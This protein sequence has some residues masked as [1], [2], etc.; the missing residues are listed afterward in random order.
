MTATSSAAPTKAAPQDRLTLVGGIT[1]GMMSFLSLVDL[2]GPQAIAPALT[3]KLGVSPGVM[4]FAINASTLG[5]AVA[6]FG[7]ALISRSLDRR[8]WIWLSLLLL[9]I[10][11]LSLTFADSIAVF[12]A[13]R[14]A[15]GVLM[16]VAFTLTLAYLAENCSATTAAGAMAAY[17]TGNVLSNLLGRLM[18]ATVAEAFGVSSVFLALAALN[19]CGAVLAVAYIGASDRR[20]ATPEIREDDKPPMFCPKEA[21]RVCGSWVQHLRNPQLLASF[22]IGFIILF[23]FIGAYTYVNYVLSGE[24]FGLDAA[25]LGLVYFVFIPSVFTTPV[26]GTV[27]K[28]MGVRAAYWTAI[29]I[30][31]SGLLALLAPQLWIVLTGLALLAV[32]LFFAQAAVTGFVGR[33]ADNERAA[34]SGLY[35][36][37]YYFGGLAGAIALGRVFE[38]FGWPASVWFMVA[39]L[40][41]SAALAVTL[42]VSSRAATAA[43]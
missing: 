3:A 40:G 11:T 25:A 2:F 12:A 7:I 16:A 39:M 10:P 30:S 37:S 32:G 22:A 43:V 18:S 41:L 38:L 31:V 9:T 6:G 13:L 15:Q 29:A 20:A 28:R 1:I 34:A 23:V 26:A 27:A 5:M 4:G 17:I 19:V 21:S 33:A 8:L 14:V 36:S 24:M 42:R 35:L